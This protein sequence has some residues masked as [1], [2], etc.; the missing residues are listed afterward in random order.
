MEA[1]HGE[2]IALDNEMLESLEQQEILSRS[3]EEDLQSGLTAGQRLADRVAA[4]GGSWRFLIV[5]TVFVI[6]W[7]AVNSVRLDRPTS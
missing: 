2:L 5:F 6:L 1:A 7:I 3:P 4:F